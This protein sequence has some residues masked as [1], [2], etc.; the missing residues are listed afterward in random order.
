MNVH[1]PVPTVLEKIVE[2]PKVVP[3]TRKAPNTIGQIPDVPVQLVMQKRTGK[4]IVDVAAPTAQDHEKILHVPVPLQQHVIV[5]V[6]KAATRLAC[7]I[8]RLSRSWMFRRRS[9]GSRSGRCR[10]SSL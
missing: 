6:T 7:R 3:N 5:E 1:A 4:Q 10:R 9:C 2:V 8:G